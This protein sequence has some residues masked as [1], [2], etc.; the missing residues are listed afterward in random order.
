ML[1]FLPCVIIW[2][3]VVCSMWGRISLHNIALIHHIENKLIGP[4]EQDVSSMFVALLRHMCSR[5]WEIDPMK[6]WETA[7]SVKISGF[8]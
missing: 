1:T 5:G 7:T 8:P 6:I 3:K 4:N 2:S